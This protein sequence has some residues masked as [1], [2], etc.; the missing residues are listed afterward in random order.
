MQ[1]GQR[2]QQ[3]EA[4]I[5]L[6]LRRGGA[7]LVQRHVDRVAAGGEGDGVAAVARRKNGE[8]AIECLFQSFD[9]G[10][11]G[12]VAAKKVDGQD[13]FGTEASPA[14]LIERQGV[15]GAGTRLGVETVDEDVVKA[16]CAAEH[17]VGAAA[18]DNIEP[19]RIGRQPEVLAGN[20]FDLW[21]DLDGSDPAVR[22]V[23]IDELGQRSGAQ[24]DQQGRFRPIRGRAEQQASHHLSGVGQFQRPWPGD[25]HG[26]LHPV[27]AEVQVAHAVFFADVYG[28]A[29]CFSGFPHGVALLK[30]RPHPESNQELLLRR[31]QP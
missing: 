4:R 21:V 15:E 25:A 7:H 30:W 29:G 18:N 20:E 6:Q 3:V 12:F 14:G 11:E 8:T 2:W 23:A 1:A 24:A 16:A 31:E 13:P 19:L 27:R 26:T 10:R 22:Q 5:L 28:V 9:A 17:I